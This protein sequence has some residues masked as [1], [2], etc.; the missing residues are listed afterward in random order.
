MVSPSFFYEC[1]GSAFDQLLKPGQAERQPA[2]PTMQTHEQKTCE[3]SREKRGR[4]VD[5]SREH[6]GKDEAENGVKR[7][8]FRQ[9]TFV[10]KAYDYQCHNENNYT[11]QPDLNETQ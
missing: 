2:H 10:R 8:H 9:E 11:A 4:S 5:G 7:R 6:R 3:K 1:L